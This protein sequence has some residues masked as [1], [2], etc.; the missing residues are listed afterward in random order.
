MCVCVCA[1]VCLLTDLCVEESVHGSPRD[2]G[3][4]NMAS[5]DLL[6]SASQTAHQQDAKFSFRSDM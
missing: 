3:L 5:D 4:Q 1:C 2:D 6:D